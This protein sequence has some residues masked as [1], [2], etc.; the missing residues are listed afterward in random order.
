MEWRESKIADYDKCQWTPWYHQM[1]ED[2]G[3][4]SNNSCAQL[5]KIIQIPNSIFS[6]LTLNDLFQTLLFLTPET[7]EGDKKK[8]YITLKFLKYVMAIDI[9]SYLV[10]NQIFYNLSKVD[11]RSN[12]PLRKNLLP[13]EKLLRTFMDPSC[14]FLNINVS[15]KT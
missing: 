3:F 7:L 11:F 15:G 9:T 14:A 2:Q 5:G 6:T 13:L 10:K 4:Q 1:R 12:G 8:V